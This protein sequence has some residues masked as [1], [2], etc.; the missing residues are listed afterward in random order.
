MEK[1]P[2]TAG[3]L[4]GIR[5]QYLIFENGLVF[6]VRKHSGMETKILWH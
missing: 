4:E 2:H 3:V 1:Q 6:N 5:G